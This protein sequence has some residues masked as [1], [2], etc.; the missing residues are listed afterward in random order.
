MSKT[1]LLVSTGSRSRPLH[2][3]EEMSWCAAAVLNSLYPFAPFPFGPG[4]IPNVNSTTPFRIAVTSGVSVQIFMSSAAGTEH[5]AGNPLCPSICTRQVRQAPMAPMS[6]SLQSW[7]MY[8]PEPLTA[9][10]TEEPSGASVRCPFMYSVTVI[11]WV[12]DLMT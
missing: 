4:S 12:P 7:E 11:L 10:S 5:E 6:A 3:G 9:S 8:V 2:L 1:G